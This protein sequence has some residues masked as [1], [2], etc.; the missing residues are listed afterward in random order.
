MVGNQGYI[1]WPSL[2]AWQMAIEATR[3]ASSWRPR[4]AEFYEVLEK[5]Y[6]PRAKACCAWVYFPGNDDKYYDDNAWA[7]A[8]CAEPYEVTKDARYLKRAAAVFDAFVESGGDREKGGV[9]WGTKPGQANRLD[10]TVSV[11]ATA[12]LAGL[13][14]ERASGSSKR[15]AGASG[16][17]TGSARI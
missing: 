15:R 4:V 9:R 13:L 6:D 7:A 8:A 3:H 5:Y 2:L 11:T 1:S 16:R 17:S 10:R 12:P 14:I